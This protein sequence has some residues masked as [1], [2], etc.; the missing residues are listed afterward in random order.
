MKR[1]ACWQNFTLKKTLHKWGSEIF[2]QLTTFEPGYI[3]SLSNIGFKMFMMGQNQ[4]TSLI[5]IGKMYPGKEIEKKRCESG[6]ILDGFHHLKLKKYI[7]N[8]HICMF[9]FSA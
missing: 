6:V 2:T 5:S 4:A 1:N 8:F 9:F 7:E 3:E